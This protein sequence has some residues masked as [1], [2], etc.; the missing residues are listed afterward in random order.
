MGAEGSWYKL[1]G[2]GGLEEGLGPDYV[3]YD[4]A[5]LCGIVIS[6]T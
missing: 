1:P 6:L 3:A 4:Y 5:L 2:S